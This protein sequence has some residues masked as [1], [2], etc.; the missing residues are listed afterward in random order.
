MAKNPD[1]VRFTVDMSKEM[2]ELLD[3][4]ATDAHRSKAD[5]IRY[6]IMMMNQA[7]K[8]IREGKHIGIVSD[9]GK[10]DKEFLGITN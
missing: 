8:A 3:Q 4:T 1:T 9:E 7:V 2:F 5:A 6:G 10:L